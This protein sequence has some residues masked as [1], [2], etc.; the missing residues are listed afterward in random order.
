MKISRKDL[1]DNPIFT[2]ERVVSCE[3]LCDRSSLS[4]HQYAITGFTAS[5][6]AA[7]TMKRV[8]SA[9]LNFAGMLDAM[10]ID[11]CCFVKLFCNCSRRK[12][13][14][15]GEE[16]MRSSSSQ[17]DR[18]NSRRGGCLRPNMTRALRGLGTRKA[19]RGSSNNT[20]LCS[21]T[22][23]S[24]SS[25]YWTRFWQER[26][27]AGG[28]LSAMTNHVLG[29]VSASRRTEVRFLQLPPSSSFII[30]T[31]LKFESKKSFELPP[32]I[33]TTKLIK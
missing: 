2:Y 26:E 31:S 19:H 18:M 24:R 8:R 12:G 7:L 4:L 28:V 3:W 27:C 25:L 9:A 30:T 33:S 22:T 16:G 13:G 29:S 15:R 11:C 21:P 10:V 1:V 20:G 23:K 14:R 32:A 17:A 5:S 6:C